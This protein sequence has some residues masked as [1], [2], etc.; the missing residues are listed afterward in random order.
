MPIRYETDGAI[1]TITIDNGRLSI[2]QPQMHKEM[3][4]VLTE[5]SADDA[6]HV[7]IM[8]GADG[9][10][11]C[12]G[13]DLK[14]KPED[15]SNRTMLERQ[16]STAKR[17]SDPPAR[18]GWDQEILRLER[19]KPII[20][21]V[22][23]YALG[24][25]FMMLTHL[26]DLRICTPDA[27]FGLPEVAYGMGGIGGLLRLGRQMPH[28]AAMWCMLTAERFSAEKAMEWHYVN[29]IVPR[30][31]LA[32]R[33]REIAEKVASLPPLAV[34]VE[35]ESYQRG[36]DMSR[37]DAVIM[38]GHLYRM[39]VLGGALEGITPAFMTKKKDD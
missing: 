10:S 8:K 32:G 14:W 35:M 7:A 28:T 24:Q 18:P 15:P 13:D 21:A 39:S 25:G 3:H 23:G 26:T 12:A 2:M 9:C 4:R 27:E 31:D 34:R 30:D 17:R 6:V 37:E 16:L 29:E 38:M 33:A 19:F 22:D 5:F 1:A 11:F 36:M 20:A